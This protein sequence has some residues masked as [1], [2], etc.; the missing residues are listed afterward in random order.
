MSYCGDEGWR[1]FSTADSLPNTPEAVNDLAARCCAHDPSARPTFRVILDELTAPCLEDVEPTSSMVG[2]AQ[3]VEPRGAA[4]PIPSLSGGSLPGSSVLR[5]IAAA[6]AHEQARNEH[7]RRYSGQFRSSAVRSRLEAQR[8]A[9]GKG[10]EDGAFRLS[11]TPQS[12]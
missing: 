1:P 9:K 6:G 7:I 5:S 3:R 8:L 11:S 2:D 12:M 4:S 10:S